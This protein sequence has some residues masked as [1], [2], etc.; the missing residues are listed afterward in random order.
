MPAMQNIEAPV[1]ENDFA[2]CVL[3]L[4]AELPRL[5]TIQKLRSHGKILNGKREF[6]NGKWQ[7]HFPFSNSRFP[8]K[9]RK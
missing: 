2:T 6:E 3:D 5:L 7:R 8:F 4:V 9:M 1:G